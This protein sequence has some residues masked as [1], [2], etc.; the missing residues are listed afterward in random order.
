MHA[1]ARPSLQNCGS[2]WR[3]I[4]PCRSGAVQSLWPMGRTR[5]TDRSFFHHNGQLPQAAREK[6]IRSSVPRG[7]SSAE[8]GKARRRTGR[9]HHQPV[10]FLPAS[11]R[12]PRSAM[13]RQ[14][15]RPRAG[16]AVG[17]LHKAQR[18]NPRSLQDHG[19]RR[20]QLS[21]PSTVPLETFEYKVERESGT[22]RRAF[23]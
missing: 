1:R 18:A 15:A 10:S 22:P 23:Q 5:T 21:S 7:L 2:E 19:Y 20:C 12:W 3:R 6:W 17:M 11:N 4:K 16:V 8:L 13:R 14:D 9:F